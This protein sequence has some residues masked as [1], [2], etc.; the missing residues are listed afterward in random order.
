MPARADQGHGEP[1]AC[2]ETA[3]ATTAQPIAAVS[4]RGALSA[5]MAAC[6]QAFAP[7]ASSVVAVQPAGHG[8]R[9]LCPL[10][11]TVVV[12]LASLTSLTP[13]LP[14]S[15]LAL[16]TRDRRLAS[17][18]SVARLASVLLLSREPSP[19]PAI[20]CGGASACWAMPHLHHTIT[21]T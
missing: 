14:P 17:S 7:S 9:P 10:Q 11:H 12:S 6:Q 18:R 4:G 8:C 20:R 1:S 3:T 5:D 15:P 13:P 19:R 16:G 2:L 21:A